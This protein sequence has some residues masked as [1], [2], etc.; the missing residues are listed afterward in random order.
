MG[1]LINGIDIPNN[2]HECIF[3]MVC[4]FPVAQELAKE[5]YAKRRHQGCPLVEIPDDNPRTEIDVTEV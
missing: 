1:V 2:C 3:Y 5:E 4:D